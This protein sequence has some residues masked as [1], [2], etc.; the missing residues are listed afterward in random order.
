MFQPSTRVP[1]QGILT[2]ESVGAYTGIQLSNHTGRT[3]YIMGVDGIV[4]DLVSRPSYSYIKD[5][6]PKICVR[7]DARYNA[8]PAHDGNVHPMNTA[9]GRYDDIYIT[10]MGELYTANGL[11]TAV[12]LPQ[13]NVSVS[14]VPDTNLLRQAHPYFAPAIKTD[15]CEFSR[16][17]INLHDTSKQHM[18]VAGSHGISK[19]MVTH[20]MTK[21]EFIRFR[22]RDEFGALKQYR[23]DITD[24]TDVRCIDI[25]YDRF[26]LVMGIAPEIV[27]SRFDELHNGPKRELVEVKKVLENTN[28]ELEIT[29][30]ENIVLKKKVSDVVNRE[31][32]VH[33]LNALKMKAEI[34]DAEY[35]KTKAHI[36]ADKEN[37]P[38]KMQRESHKAET[39]LA[40]AQA[41][42]ATAES[43]NKA[44]A[45]KSTAVVA[46]AAATMGVIATKVLTT[47]AIAGAASVAGAAVSVSAV[48]VAVAAAVGITAAAL[49]NRRVRES[50]SAK[51][52]SALRGSCSLFRSCVDSTTNCAKKAVRTVSD[53]GKAIF[54]KGLDV[55]KSV[56]GGTIDAVRSVGRTVS[57]TV[58]SFCSTVSGWF[59]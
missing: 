30:N 9:A 16:L 43:D 17:M 27:R 48:P 2:F 12:Y 5:P 29:K 57:G 28:R 59:F 33:E 54:N 41:K 3:I 1:S 37:I 10:T 25:G 22:V 46:G 34:A 13:A 32:E 19:V 40:V 51:V 52:K 6:S 56:V 18:Y 14:L 11:P 38:L 23:L 49:L 4:H 8:E 53:C 58:G 42:L 50:I 31:T 55:A 21:P 36:E 47:S 44:Q 20:D 35:A 7:V 24:A 39:D 45:W 15:D 26:G